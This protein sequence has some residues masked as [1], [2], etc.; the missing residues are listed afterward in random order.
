MNDIQEN[1]GTK[2]AT[3]IGPIPILLTAFS[4]YS[5]FRG[6][7]IRRTDNSV[8][9]FTTL[10]LSSLVVTSSFYSFNNPSFLWLSFSQTLTAMVAYALL[11]IAIARGENE[12]AL[13]TK[14]RSTP[15]ALARLA[16]VSSAAVV[17]LNAAAPFLARPCTRP[18]CA[19]FEGLFGALDGGFQPYYLLNFFCGMLLIGVCLSVRHILKSF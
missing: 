6:L 18:K 15:A 13:L 12:P 1:A 11:K 10:L 8:V 7:I 14:S 16:L 9:F 17:G 3:I 19:S 5:Y 2:Y 4:A